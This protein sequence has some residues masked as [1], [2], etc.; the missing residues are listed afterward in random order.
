MYNHEQRITQLEQT[1]EELR[2]RIKQLE[3]IIFPSNWIP[4]KQAASQLGI[5]HRVIL[6]AISSQKLTH[7]KDYK[8]NGRTYLV[9][10][11]NVEKKLV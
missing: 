4:P 1:N 11:K 5:S 2:Q 6:N 10:V 8:K 9:N 3:K 7:K